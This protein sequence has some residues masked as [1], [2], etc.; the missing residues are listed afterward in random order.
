MPW[1]SLGLAAV[2]IGTSIFNSR[3][4]NASTRASNKERKRQFERQEDWN[5]AQYNYSE[6]QADVAYAWDMA[7][8]EALKY[9]E[10]ENKLYYEF[11]QDQQLDYA[12]KNLELNSGALMDQY[13]T[14]ENL[15]AKQEMLNLG[16]TTDRNITQLQEQ[17]LRAQDLEAQAQL[18]KIQSQTQI[19]DFLISV[20]E[21]ANAQDR[22]MQ[23]QKQETQALLG[24][25]ATDIMV[26]KFERDVTRVAQ[27]VEEGQV[28]ARAT[29]R[30]GG[31]STARQLAMNS[32]KALGRT[33]GQLKIN[34]DKRNQQV[35]AQNLQNKG[36]AMQMYGVALQTSRAALRGEEVAKTGDIRQRQL[37]TQMAGV[38]LASQQ[39]AAEQQFT[40]DVYENL[41]VPGFELAQKQGQR[42]Q[43]ALELNTMATMTEASMPYRDPIIFEP[44]RALPGLRPFSE[45][46][47]IQREQSLGSTIGGAVLAGAQGFLSGGFKKAGGGIGFL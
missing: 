43:S 24:S 39:T 11:A 38:K 17:G 8:H 28:K 12:I 45:G 2:G 40:T 44:Q 9:T 31:T 7:K 36:T 33:Y 13:V 3:S 41:T 6:I 10:A 32:A 20:K 35:I 30:T 15:R 18:N 1:L 16:L 47:T 37:R 34:Q 26:E 42:E 46:P 25:I 14:A 29:V 5:K 27:Q 19:K 21:N 23:R 4:R 22:L